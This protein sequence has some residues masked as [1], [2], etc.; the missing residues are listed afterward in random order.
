MIFP[1]N[2]TLAKVQDQKCLKV[3]WRQKSRDVPEAEEVTDLLVFGLCRDILNV[4]GR[5]RHVG[6][7]VLRGSSEEAVVRWDRT[8][9]FR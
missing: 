9:M 2:S 1:L 8:E 6:Y 3:A 7:T 5:S 4:N